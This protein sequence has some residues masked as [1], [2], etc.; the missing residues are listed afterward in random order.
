MNK[1]LFRGLNAN[2]RRSIIWLLITPVT[3]IQ[4]SH[5]EPEIRQEKGVVI[6]HRSVDKR[7]PHNVLWGFFIGNNFLNYA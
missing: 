7:D 6:T 1:Q 3:Q 4:I 2:L 5:Q